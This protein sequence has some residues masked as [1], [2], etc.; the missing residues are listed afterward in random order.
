MKFAD[1]KVGDWFTEDSTCEI[2]QKI[3]DTDSIVIDDNNRKITYHF[4][5]DLLVELCENME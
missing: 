4:P 1:L 2:L 5:P 3:S